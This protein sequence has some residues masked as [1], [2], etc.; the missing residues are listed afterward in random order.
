M[1][2]CL[3][4][5]V[6]TILTKYSDL[7]DNKQKSQYIRNTMT[8]LLNN[9]C[10]A[11]IFDKLP[12]DKIEDQIEKNEG[13][14]SIKDMIKLLGKIENAKDFDVIQ[15]VAM[16]IFMSS[17]S[18]PKEEEFNFEEMPMEEVPAEEEV[19]KEE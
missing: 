7:K 6:K 16:E 11:T 10:V 19:L 5:N 17:M 15:E 1:V 8:A 4:K 9:E 2:K 13:D 14:L 3:A 12:F 18:S